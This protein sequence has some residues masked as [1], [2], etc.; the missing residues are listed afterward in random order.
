MSNDSA[1]SGALTPLLERDR[2]LTPAVPT[3]PKVQI[4]R[5][6]TDDSL[7]PSQQA[8]VIENQVV[9]PTSTPSPEKTRD[10][11][12][13]RRKRQRQE[14][15]IEKYCSSLGLDPKIVEG[16]GSDFNDLLTE[17][18]WQGRLADGQRLEVLEADIRREIGRAQ[19][20]GWLGHIEQQDGKIR[21]LG[22]AFDKAIE[23]CEELDGLLTLYSHELD[24]LQDDIQYI[25][26]Q[27][28]G[29]QV[30]TAN[31]KLLQ[32]ELQDLLKNLTIPSRDLQGI[33]SGSL[34][35]SD[36]LQ[37]VEHSLAV[38]YQAMLT[39]DPEVR[40][41]K[42]RQ[43]GASTGNKTSMG[44]TAKAEIRHMH[45]VEEQKHRYREE[46]SAFLRRLTEHLTRT[47]KAAEHRTS[48][49]NSRSSV[50]SPKS[51]STK[52]QV[53]FRQELWMYNALL[54]FAR[55]VNTYEWQT[56][57]RSYEMTMKG[58][59]QDQFRD[60]T[61]GRKKAV[62]GTTDDEQDIL[63][64]AQERDE[65][66]DTSL[67]SSATRKLTMKR[68]KVPK[69]SNLRPIVGERTDGQL[70]PYEIFAA[71]V[72]ELSRAVAEEQNFI[73]HFFHLNSQTTADFTELI[74]RPA[75][76]RRLPN[77]TAKQSYDPDRDMSKTVQQTVE[78]IYT[79]WPTDLQQLLEWCLASDPLQGV[80][81]LYALEQ[82][83]GSYEETNQEYVSRTLR[84][85]HE[86]LT[87]SFHKFIDEQVKAIEETK[88]KI[89]KRKGIISFMRVFPHFSNAIESMIPSSDTESLEIRFLINDAYT[90]T[91][92][93]MWESLTFIAKEDS[94]TANAGVQSHAPVSGDPEDK[95][96]L[97]YHI[98]LIENMNH[99]IEEVDT[100]AH[101]V[102]L[103]EWIEK[104]SHDLF[105]HLTQYTDAV[106][107]RPLGKWLDFLES[108]EALMK[109]AVGASDYTSVASKP[110]H[111]RSA[112]KKVLSTFDTREVR[113]GAE[114]LRKRVEKHFG[115]VDEQGL[116]V[117]SRPLVGRV[118]EECHSRYVHSWDRMKSIIEKVYE[119]GT[120][121][122]EW[123]KE[124]VGAIFRR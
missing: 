25:E 28:Q 113:K 5:T 47:F 105:T 87:A 76:Q 119:G 91:L 106:I 70:H 55:E 60:Y 35:T 40:Q 79:F 68:S 118:L 84:A 16:R 92:K 27:S 110:S 78:G 50:S 99:Y 44:G 98:L 122:M 116:H 117:G 95:E 77:L 41:N 29:L 33:H 120:L 38:L 43:G 32:K 81:I 9:I 75:S 19:A 51:L 62:R 121:E 17:F 108:T 88:V 11:S 63:F 8:S 10:R 45:A 101:N 107:R 4:Q 71:V 72:Q 39:F 20:T 54:L 31:Q 90:K 124:D 114:T 14:A 1:R 12:P 83:L 42:M 94:T 65:K 86:R 111:S 52:N 100:S 49:E 46:S 85:L 73:V 123:K 97:N 61:N 89:K 36:G 66:Q 2:P 6:A 109:T 74:S 58:S 34:D 24:T 26:A 57:V 59:H 93:A 7:K 112:A 53:A 3:T 48:D 30:Q 103:E 82:C 102:V 21:D 15:D 23:E 104:A 96:A 18:G 67:A 80:G 64:T 37:M 56:L 22:K 115:D 69:T 13:E